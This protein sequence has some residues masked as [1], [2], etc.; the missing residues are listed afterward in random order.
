M[1]LRTYW[2]ILIRRW[3]LIVAPAVVVAIHV[4][5]S[6]APPGTVYQVVMRFTAGTQP[7]GLSEDYDRYYSWLTSEYIANGLADAADGNIFA[8]AVAA[9]LAAAGHEGI[10]ANDIQ[11]AIV[12]DNAQSILVVYLTWPDAEQSVAVAEAIVA[13][14]TTNGAAYFPQLEGIEPA[15]RLQDTPT[16]VPLPPGL[17]AQLMGPAIKIG[18]AFV[19]G[20][21]LT[22]LWHYL[23]PTIREAEELESIGLDVLAQV[24]RN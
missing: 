17:R 15:V 5:V 1:E 8:Q 13:E 12:T 10:A 23:D 3:W 21:A 2:K 4:A 22:L 9:R 20:V 18:L 14:M 11:P 24:P 16:P 6:Y 7:A 19:V